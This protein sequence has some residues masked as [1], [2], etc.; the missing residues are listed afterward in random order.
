MFFRE[1]GV[2]EPQAPENFGGLGQNQNQNENF[3][4]FR[5][6]V[7]QKTKKTKRRKKTEV[8]LWFLREGQTWM[9]E[10]YLW[11]SKGKRGSRKFPSGFLEG[12]T[13]MTEVYL[14]NVGQKFT[15]GFLRS[16]P[17]VF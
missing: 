3:L 8:Y 15:S 1:A 6:G 17:L 11:F 7:A 2:R 14:V 12:Q 16:L 5:F 10:V 9:T 4:V 13:W